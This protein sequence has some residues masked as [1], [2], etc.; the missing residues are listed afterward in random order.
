MSGYAVLHK[1]PSTLH[2]KFFTFNCCFVKIKIKANGFGFYYSKDDGHE[3]YKIPYFIISV[4]VLI[5]L[6]GLCGRR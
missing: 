2:N 3:A 1:F 6:C 4:D 5:R